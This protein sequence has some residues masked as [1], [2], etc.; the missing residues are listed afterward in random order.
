[1]ELIEIFAEKIN[2]KYHNNNLYNKIIS[3]V[4]DSKTQ[5]SN[6]RHNGSLTAEDR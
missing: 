3:A 5:V 4:Y 6:N 2:V 1:M